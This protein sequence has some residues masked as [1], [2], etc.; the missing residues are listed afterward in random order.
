MNQLPILTE[1]PKDWV[2]VENTNTQPIGFVFV[3]NNKSRFGTERKLAL[4]K[5]K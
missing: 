1:L 4:L 5:I 3:S 2:V